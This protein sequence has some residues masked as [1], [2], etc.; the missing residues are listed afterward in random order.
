M[1]RVML[2]T[3]RHITI[4]LTGRQT[5]RRM[6]IAVCVLAGLVSGLSFLHP[7][8]AK[9]Q[10][11]SQQLT[12]T[13]SFT[14]DKVR[15]DAPLELRLNRPLTNTE[16]HLAVFI[17]TLDV[18]NLLS[19]TDTT[20][21]YT[22]A[23]VLL[24]PGTSEVTVWLVSPRDEWQEL[25]RLP[26]QVITQNAAPESAT[27][28]ETQADNAAAEVAKR[29]VL[30]PSLTLGLKSQAAE[31]HF[32]A[33][34]RP[35]R[36]TFA[37]LTMQGSVRAES[38][39]R[40]FNSQSQFDL[41]GSSYRNEAL[42]FA[43]LNNNAPLVD[44]S[45]YLIQAQTGRMQLQAGHI[46]YGTNRLLIGNYNSR[47]LS[48]TFPL[49]NRADF[50]VAA[51]NGT[52][53]V[54]WS[55]FFGLNRRKHQIVSG[56]LGV[57]LL[58]NRPGGLR[59]EAGAMYGSLLPLSN[60]NQGNLSDAQRSRGGSLRLVLSDPSQRF[61]L[62]GG[63]ARS[64]FTNP[65]DPLLEQDSFVVPVRETAR[66]AR[67]VEAS[68]AL[69]QNLRLSDKRAAN[70]TFNYRHEQADPLYR[71]VAAFIQADRDQHQFELVS[72]IGGIT[73]T[74]GHL[75]FHD[76]L[77]ELASILKTQTRR[78][79]FILGVPLPTLFSEQPRSSIL[80]PM[81]SYT[82]DRTHQR[83]LGL[84]V[85][86]GF[87]SLSQVP[88]Q[89]SINQNFT[90]EWQWPKL[91]M[92][93]RL[94][95][96]LQDNRQPGRELADLRNLVHGFT[97]GMNPTTALDLNLELNA[98]SAENNEMQ[99]TDRLWRLGPNFTW[100]MTPRATLMG[101]LST[102]FAGDLAHTSRSRNLELDLQ[103]SYSFGWG[104]TGLKKVRAQ[105]FVRYADRYMRMRDFTFGLDNL[106][107]L[108]T[109]NTGLT[110]TFF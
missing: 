59:L 46:T 68:A 12:V 65:A 36:P 85:N 84:P 24:P 109:L 27:A 74:A 53:I 38:N 78:N 71:S 67:Y 56:T 103:W 50:S 60:F 41:V 83:G 102:A 99:R 42:R 51:M 33:D 77:G 93:Y 23:L 9:R 8:Q 110:F 82:F 79:N 104:E 1:F 70:V 2:K 20:W 73:A 29:F 62:E 105:Y 18:T 5:V 17:G 107:R 80:L 28:P 69:L 58:R 15:P 47:G 13:A 72:D 45:N 101:T 26:L 31:S 44:L 6:G 61:K 92:G 14:S 54:G 89:L 10:I 86:S 4:R 30:T 39:G 40:R 55:N 63:F 87:D 52:S 98:E 11:A 16:G 91:R 37:D 100:R 66:N 25:V 19:L 48:L 35:E 75:R 97:L 34:N 90:A 64:S 108:R 21:R 3:C 49:S 32:P 88:D 22:P 7:A 95:H 96:S 106:T 57:E 81:L 76:N 43:E 94:N